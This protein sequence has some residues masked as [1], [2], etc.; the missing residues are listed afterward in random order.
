MITSSQVLRSV[1]DPKTTKLGTGRF[2]VIDVAYRNQRGELCGVVED[3]LCQLR[4]LAYRHPERLEEEA[5]PA[6]LRP[7]ELARTPLPGAAEPP[8]DDC[9][10]DA[11][12]GTLPDQIAEL[13]RELDGTS[14]PER[15]G[16]LERQVAIQERYLAAT[17]AVG[18]RLGPLLFP[19]AVVAL[20][21]D[22]LITSGIFVIFGLEFDLRVLAALLAILGYS[23]NDTIII[24]DRIRENME[25]RT[26]HDLVD[27]LNRSVNQTLSRSLLTSLTTLAAVLCLL[28][29]GGEVIRP[30]ALAMGIGI[31]AGTYSSAFI[32]APTRSRSPRLP[33]WRGVR[34]TTRR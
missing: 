15:R 28:V 17:E 29:V 8:L 20:V 19:G 5:S 4:A 7:L 2:W 6:D 27:V 22:V 18:R 24:Y 11:F 12:V 10:Y 21:H 30:F 34:T 13:R 32:A 14:D 31:V 25:L 9:A 16:Q 3:Q 1:S 33:G 26:K 23:L